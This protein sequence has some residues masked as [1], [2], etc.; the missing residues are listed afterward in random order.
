MSLPVYTQENYHD[1][2]LWWAI[3]FHINKYPTLSKI[4]K[5][6]LSIF[7]GPQVES[8]F[9]TMNIV[10]PRASCLSVDKYSSYMSP[11]YCLISE[12]KSAAVRYSR[13]M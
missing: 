5:A 10:T 11:K 12:E 8:S 13:R 1:I 7:S 3:I 4:I 2:Y 9:T 6:A